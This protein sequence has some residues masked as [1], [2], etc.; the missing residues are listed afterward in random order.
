MGVVPLPPPAWMNREELVE[1]RDFL[2]RCRRELPFA[3]LVRRPKNPYRPGPVLYEPQ[4]RWLAKPAAFPSSDFLIVLAA[5]APWVVSVALK[6][7]IGDW[8]I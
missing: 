8:T 1:Y 6:L 3:G 5:L 2:E 4:S 7:W